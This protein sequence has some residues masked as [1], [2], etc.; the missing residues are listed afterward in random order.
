MAF[1]EKHF[2]DEAVNAPVHEAQGN[3]E[4]QCQRD[5]CR[6]PELTAGL[7][8]PLL[9]DPLQ[10]DKRADEDSRDRRKDSRAIDDE[11][12]VVEASLQR[13]IRQPERHDEQRQSYRGAEDSLLKRS[14][15]SGNRHDV[16]HAERRKRPANPLPLLVARRRNCQYAAQQNRK[17][18]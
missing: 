7:A 3:A 8:E 5:I 9:E 10:Q 11:P 13:G 16:Q 1:F 12:D 18:R 15:E 4:E 6:K 17:P 14:G 2:V